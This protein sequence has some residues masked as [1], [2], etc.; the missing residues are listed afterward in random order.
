MLLRLVRDQI[1]RLANHLRGPMLIG[2]SF[3][4]SWWGDVELDAGVEEAQDDG[5][6]RSN[7][8]EAQ[9]NV[10]WI[11]W[12]GRDCRFKVSI[13]LP[14]MQKDRMVKMHEFFSGFWG[15]FSIRCNC[16]VVFA[17]YAWS[18]M[19]ISRSEFHGRSIGWICGENSLIRWK[20]TNACDWS[21]M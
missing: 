21:I 16:P 17:S 14:L 5:Q 3:L 13:L 9:R 11:S 19:N 1:H 15:C 10:L 18:W 7:E 6:R 4:P 8:P 20:T 2:K 12:I